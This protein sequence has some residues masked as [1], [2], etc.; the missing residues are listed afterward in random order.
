MSVTEWFQFQAADFYDIGILKLVPRYDKCHNFR[1]NYI[2][3]NS[4]ILAVS[5]PINIS[6]KLVSVSPNGPR[7]TYFSDERRIITP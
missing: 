5:V 3:K 1:R 4:S 7:E 6:I 2:E